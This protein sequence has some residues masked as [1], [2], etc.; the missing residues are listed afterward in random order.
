MKIFSLKNGALG[1]L[2]ILLLVNVFLVFEKPGNNSFVENNSMSCVDTILLKN[3]LRNLPLKLICEGTFMPEGTIAIDYK[4]N[5]C[6]IEDIFGNRHI[7]L[8]IRYSSG[9][10]QTCITDLINLLKECVPEK[11]L[12]NNVIFLLRNFENRELKKMEL[13][14]QLGSKI[15]KVDELIT[16]IDYENIPYFFCVDYNGTI[17]NVFIPINSYSSITEL[18]LKEISKC[19]K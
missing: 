5:T 11:V 4:G 16:N 1:V 10:C 14:H 2:F 18:Y 9:N 7:S 8:V 19:L 13:L 12:S 6:K 3:I 17:L 15:Y